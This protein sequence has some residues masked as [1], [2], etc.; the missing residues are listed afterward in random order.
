MFLASFLSDASAAKE[1]ACSA[2]DTGDMDLIPELGRSPG[3]ERAT[4][5][6]FLRIQATEA[7]RLQSES[8][9]TEH[10]NSAQKQAVFNVN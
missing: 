6:V 2:W 3:E 10:I 7:S 9:T 4:T 5:P 8:D 1:S